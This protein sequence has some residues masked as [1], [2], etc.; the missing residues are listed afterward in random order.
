MAISRT[1]RWK[2]AVRAT[3][4]VSQ[5][6]SMSTPTRPPGW[7]YESTTPSAAMRLALAVEA[8]RPF[9]RK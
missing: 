5:L 1:S 8:A 3:K 4:S 9:L 6:S 2:P 7:M